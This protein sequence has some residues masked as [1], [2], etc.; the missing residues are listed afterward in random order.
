M[1]SFK[2]FWLFQVRAAGERV[3]EKESILARKKVVTIV[4]FGFSQMWKKTVMLR[5]LGQLSQLF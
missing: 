4:G 2:I 3:A 1:F 5:L